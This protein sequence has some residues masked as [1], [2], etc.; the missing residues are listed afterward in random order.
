MPDFILR[1]NGRMDPDWTRRLELAVMRCDAYPK[2]GWVVDG[3]PTHLVS[4]VLGKSEFARRLLDRLTRSERRRGF[5]R[6][7]SGEGG[8]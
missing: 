3:A 6:R 2:A 1:W 4:L 8:G 7:Q 5:G